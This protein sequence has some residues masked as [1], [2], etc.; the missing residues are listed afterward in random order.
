M[1][2]DLNE[3]R[4]E[5][6]RLKRMAKKLKELGMS[7]KAQGYEAEIEGLYLRLDELERQ[8]FWESDD[9]YN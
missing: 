9:E 3:Y 1:N 2:P 8:Y 4:D 6:D 7:D 5:I